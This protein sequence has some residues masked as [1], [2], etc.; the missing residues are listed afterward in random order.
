M[1][2]YNQE[3]YTEAAATYQQVV[4]IDSTYG[5]AHSNLAESYRQLEQFE[6]ANAQYTVAAEYVKNDPDLY[7]SWGY[8]LGKENKFDK[9]AVRLKTAVE[10]KGDAVDYSNVA[11]A[12]NRA[13]QEDVKASREADAAAKLEESKAAAE[14]ATEIN[15][16]LAAGYVNLGTS[17][18]GLGQYDASVVALRRAVELRDDWYFAHNELGQALRGL[19]QLAMAIASFQKV[20]NLNQNFAMGFFNLGSAQHANGDKKA[21]EQT[22]KQLKKLNPELA[23]RLDGVIKGRIKNEINKRNPLNK[24]PKLPF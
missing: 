19:G 15:P 3:K 11:W 20:V 7:T 21:A 4:A 13:A 18:N 14:R 2:Q 24:L 1:A 6:K 8:C 17:L 12:Y 9:A 16:N 23:G 22:M 10:M 5:D